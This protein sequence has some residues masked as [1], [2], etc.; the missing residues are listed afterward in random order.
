MLRLLRIC[1]SYTITLNCLGTIHA[2][3]NAVSL[4]LSLSPIYVLLSGIIGNRVSLHFYSIHCWIGVITFVG[5][6]VQFLSALAFYVLN[7][8]HVLS[9]QVMDQFKNLHLIIGYSVF[10]LLALSAV[11]GISE[12]N[13]VTRYIYHHLL[14]KIIVYLTALQL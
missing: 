14:L 7:Y 3:M 6:I 10:Y 9:Q 13:A 1:S 2:L 5:L 4:V 8:I 11:L 12:M